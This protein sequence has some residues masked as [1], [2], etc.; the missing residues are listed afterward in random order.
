MLK[1]QSSLIA[2]WTVILPIVYMGFIFILSSILLQENNQAGHSLIRQMMQNL[3]HIP[4]FGLLAFLW[5]KAFEN[6]KFR[7]KRAFI[8]S[9]IITSCYAAFDE[10]HQFFITGRYAT[11][12]DF[13][14]NIIGCVGGLVVYALNLNRCILNAKQ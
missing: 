3:L 9:I 10:L 13:L 1:L 11:F 4:L 2:K 12:V 7:L 14:L 5:M 8:Y 6:C